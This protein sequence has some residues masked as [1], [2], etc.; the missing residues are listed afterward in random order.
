MRLLVA[1]AALLLA[2]PAWAGLS[3]PLPAPLYV[4]PGT[5]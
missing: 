1:A 2:T 3:F 5:P 4:A